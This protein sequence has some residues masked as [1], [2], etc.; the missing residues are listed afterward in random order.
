MLHYYLISERTHKK[1]NCF[2]VSACVREEKDDE[3]DRTR[4]GKGSRKK[5]TWKESGKS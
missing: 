4:W 3:K 1:V 5:W 2:G